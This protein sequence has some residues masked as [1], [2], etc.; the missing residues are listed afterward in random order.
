MYTNITGKDIFN[1]FDE[2]DKDDIKKLSLNDCIDLTIKFATY[3][4]TEKPEYSEKE[5]DN[6]IE[7]L[8]VIPTEAKI[9]FCKFADSLERVGESFKYMCGVHSKCSL[10]NSKYRKEFMT[11]VEEAWEKLSQEEKRK[12]IKL[13]NWR[14]KC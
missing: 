7:F 4:A 6:T 13:Y 1:K 10:K 8:T 3:L 14:I 5:I 2:Y 9:E 12:Y 11:E